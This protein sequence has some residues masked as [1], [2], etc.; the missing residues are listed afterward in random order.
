MLPALF[1]FE[2][3]LAE[4]VKQLGFKLGSRISTTKPFATCTRD[5][6]YKLGLLLSLLLLSLLRTAAPLNFLVSFNSTY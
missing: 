2:I 6:W 4:N 3:N 5:G 1:I